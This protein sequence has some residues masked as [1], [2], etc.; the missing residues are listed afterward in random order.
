[1]WVDYIMMDAA[2][3]GKKDV[4]R[5]GA[6]L[7]RGAGR[8]VKIRATNRRAFARRRVGMPVG[9]KINQKGGVT[10]TTQLF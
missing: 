2:C 4:E 6:I 5:K 1:M 3:F 9:G 8:R 7:R 10:H